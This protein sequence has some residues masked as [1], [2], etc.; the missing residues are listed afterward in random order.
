MLGRQ[1]VDQRRRL[2]QVADHDDR[3]VIAPAGGGDRPPRQVAE[4]RLDRRRDRIGE[5]ARRR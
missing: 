1:A 4:L 3:A 2:G 5:A